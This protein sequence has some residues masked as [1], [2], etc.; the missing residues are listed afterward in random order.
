MDDARH[1]TSVIE[2]LTN[3]VW[4]VRSDNRP[5]SVIEPKQAVLIKH[6]V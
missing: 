2:A 6:L 3:T 4:Q 1:R 5:L